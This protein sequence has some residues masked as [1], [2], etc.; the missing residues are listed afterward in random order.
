MA[1]DGGGL[2]R[3]AARTLTKFGSGWAVPAD[4]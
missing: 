4:R 1:R 3:T 2:A